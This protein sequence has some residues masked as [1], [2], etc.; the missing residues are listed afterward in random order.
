VA[1]AKMRRVFLIGPLD[2]R[3]KAMQCLQDMG[4]VHV[5]PAAKISG[6]L[7]KRNAA[8]QQEVRRAH[9]VYEEMSRF[10][11]GEAKTRAA[12]PDDQLV[13]Y[14]E[15]RLSELQEVQNRKQ[16]LQKLVT[17]LSIWENFAPEA[18]QELERDGIYVQRFRIEG[19]LPPDFHAPEDAYMEVVSEKPA[20]SFFTIR[21]GSAVDIPHAIQ[22]R[23]PEI[24][25][26][27]AL[28]ELGELRE[29]EARLIDECEAAKNR[30]GALKEQ[31]N[32]VL[33][34]ASYTEHL[35]TLYSEEH[36]FGLQGWVPADL[37][38][39]LMKEIEVSKLP[40]MVTARD[41]LEGETPPT[42]FKNNWFIRR[43]EPLLKL[44]GLPSYRSLDPSYFFAPFMV[45][46]FGICLGDAGY[47][48]VFLLASVWIRKKWGHLSRELP[49]VMKLC[50]AFSVSAIVIGLLTGSVFGYSFTNR[51]WVLVDLDIDVGNPM[52]LFY[53]SLGLGVVHLSFSYLL[54]M[55]D[56]QSRNE[57]LQKLG[58]MAV[59][60]GGAFLISR[61]I[62][63]L[64]PASKF[65]VLFNYAGWGLLLC[66]VILTF[67]SASD[68]KRWVVR[69]GL[70]FWGVYGLTG[71]VGD[72]LSYARLFGLGIATT[73]IAAV[74]NQLAGMV[75]NATGPVIGAV[76]A[77]LLL[78]LGH[79][80]NLALSILGSTVHS[81]RLH[82]VEAF[83]SFFRGGGI[84]YKPFKVE[85]G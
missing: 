33:N 37:E 65:N 63:F 41:P 20:Y 19:K 73:A 16:S 75:Y 7:E 35:G 1:L 76:L 82:F 67:L 80:F 14:C 12:V 43:I 26:A 62:W 17:E 13:P 45:L 9:Q 39:G 69:I 3:E 40:L 79:T 53:A 47:G 18:I 58:L 10:K 8:L 48:L 49:L 2:E 78:I 42:L 15:S 77:V 70:G 25:L 60:W 34:E 46:F 85:R 71:L 4:V 83:R 84:Q 31:Y 72:L 54:G 51:E 29:E 11:A 21:I 74:M 56:A 5:E 68:S 22:L 6:E 38:D 61:N 66:G 81:A 50:Q 36:L 44:Y 32:I 55:L 30:I 23:L 64:E 57:M 59:L 52:I 27:R 28:D 24:G